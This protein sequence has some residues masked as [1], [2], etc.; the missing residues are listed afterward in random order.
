MVSEGM[1]AVDV[2]RDALRAQP[3]VRVR[4]E[5][6][7]MGCGFRGVGEAELV[8]AEHPLRPGRIAVYRTGAGW[9]AHRII[10]RFEHRGNR[11]Y[12]TKGDGFRSVDRIPVH[13]TSVAGVVGAVCRDGTFQ[14]VDRGW[15]RVA[16]LLH[17]V[18]GGI[19]WRLHRAEIIKNAD[20]ST[21]HPPPSGRG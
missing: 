17:T 2:L 16:A 11:W 18:A 21:A 4:V 14:P 6:S 13:E 9:T 10:A 12:V 7:S 15:R 19:S 20:A 8:A 1:D 5:G 3:T